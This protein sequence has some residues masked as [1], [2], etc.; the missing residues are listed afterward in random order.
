MWH[1]ISDIFWEENQDL[2]RIG[3]VIHITASKNAVVK[4]ETLPKIG[5]R[6]IDEKHNL[7]GKVFDIFGPTSSPYVEVR[8][9]VKDP[10]ELVDHSLYALPSG[11]KRGKKDE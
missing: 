11:N 3:R 4:A 5:D 2:Q 1:L 6:V 8:P 10:Y 9:K 7:V